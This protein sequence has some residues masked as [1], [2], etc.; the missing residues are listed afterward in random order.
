MLPVEIEGE[1]GL[2]HQSLRH[3]VVKHRRHTVHRDAA[4]PTDTISTH[5]PFISEYSLLR[6]VLKDKTVS[7]HCVVR[8]VN[9]RTTEMILVSLLKRSSK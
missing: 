2:L 8:N 5:T 9:G 6:L 1:D 3:H 4:T 7:E